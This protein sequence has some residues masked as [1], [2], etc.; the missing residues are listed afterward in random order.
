MRAQ[1]MLG[2]V[3]L[4]GMLVHQLCKPLS[5]RRLHEPKYL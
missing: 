4:A 2:G 5:L 1:S 3:M